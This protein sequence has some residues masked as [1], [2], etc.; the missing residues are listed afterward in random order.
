MDRFY[1]DSTPANRHRSPAMLPF[2]STL[3][4]KRAGPC[5]NSVVWYWADRVALA[6]RGFDIT[7]ID[8]SDGMLTMARRKAAG[9]PASVRDRLTLI[10]QTV[11]PFPWRGDSPS[12]LARG[13]PGWWAEPQ[14][15]RVS[16][17]RS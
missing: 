5:S 8:V 2:T 9:R 10:N 6:E 1:E 11:C 14:T 17:E 15:R 4:A 13:L 7:G 3:R 16:H 12:M